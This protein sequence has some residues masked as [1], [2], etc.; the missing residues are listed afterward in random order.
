MLNSRIIVGHLFYGVH[1]NLLMDCSFYMD[2]YGVSIRVKPFCIDFITFLQCINFYKLLLATCI[3]HV[4][5]Q[6]L[7]YRILTQKNRDLKHYSA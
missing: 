1:I 2:T 7:A 5:C 4:L 3:Q 6:S